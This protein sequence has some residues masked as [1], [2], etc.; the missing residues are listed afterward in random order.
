[1]LE[2]AT[3]MFYTDSIRATGVDTSVKRAG[4]SK[5]TLYA[6][7]GSALWSPTTAAQ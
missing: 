2:T 4:V 6:R 7:F 3:E 5:P 1:L